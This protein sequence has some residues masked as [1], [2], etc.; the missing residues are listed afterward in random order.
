MS[1]PP[2]GRR[3]PVKKADDVGIMKRLAFL[4]M[5]VFALAADAAGVMGPA[6]LH[7]YQATIAA[8]LAKNEFGGPLL[9]KSDESPRRIEG[10]VYAVLEHPFATVSN[11]LSE[12]ANWCDVLILHLNT[13]ACRRANEGGK[14]LVQIRVGKKEA[15][16][17]E[18]ASLLSFHW[19]GATK[20]DDYFTIAMDAD[21]GPYDTS[22]YRLFVE[23]VPLDAGHTFMHMGYAF[24]YGGASSFA[25][26]LYL[27]TIGRNKIGFTRLA[28]GYVG[29]VRGIAERNTMRYYLAID[30]YLDSLALPK[31]QQVEKRIAQWFDA[32]EKYPRQLHEV[33]RDEYLPMKREEVKRK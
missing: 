12:P 10:D 11:A 26:K 33:D 4:A 22:N 3:S 7:A 14:T 32:T 18:D 17:A 28:D 25:M 20:R 27:A 30:A 9:L 8:Q 29:G 13:K 1:W 31:E 23:A 16:A 5:F 6:A 2:D 21:E 24:S 15:Q 19:L